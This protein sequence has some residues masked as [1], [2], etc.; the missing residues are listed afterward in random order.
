MTFYAWIKLLH[1]SAIAL[2]SA[3]L[4]Y[5]PALF[6]E[7][8]RVEED[9]DFRRLRHRTR[10]TYVVFTSPA[11]VIA[12]V[13]GTMMI[14]LVSNLGI[15]LVYKLVGVGLMVMLHVY[16]GRLMGQLYDQPDRRRPWQHLVMLVPVLLVISLVVLV[17]SAKPI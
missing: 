12:V 16:F 6:A 2:W 11:G 4:V 7:H 3:G 15:W 8:A 1:I 9:D 14:P 17:V 10:L 13:T 5:L